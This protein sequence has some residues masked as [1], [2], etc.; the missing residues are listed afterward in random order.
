MHFD[1]KGYWIEILDKNGNEKNE[2]IMGMSKNSKWVLHGPFLDKTLIRN[3]IWYNLS[4]EIMEYAPNCRFCELFVN[5]EYKGLYLMVESISRINL[6]ISKFEKDSLYNSYIVRLDDGSNE[7][8]KNIETSGILNKRF[9][10]YSKM[11][12][13]YPTKRNLTDKTINFI[14]QDFNEFE[15][16]LN[17]DSYMNYKDYIDEES[18]IDYF[19]INELSMN[20]DAGILSTYLYKEATGKLKFCVWDFNNACDNYQERAMDISEWVLVE[21]NWYKMLLKNEDFANN[22]IERY[23]ELRKTYFNEEYIN[24][25]IDETVEFLGDSIERNFEV[26]GY[27]FEQEENLLESYSRNLHSYDEAVNQLKDVIKKRLEYMDNNI[28]NIKY[29][30][31]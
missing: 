2:K 28:E 1:K 14:I 30:G 31:D 13:V 10:E 17:S 29:M 19:L 25:K 27:T 5:N 6:N 9:G 12:I 4:G 7:E 26:W 23:R 8:I 16:C 20:Y 3:Y 21:N 22:I 24:T 11:N 15:D 18:F